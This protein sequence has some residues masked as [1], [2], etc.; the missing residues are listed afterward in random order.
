MYIIIDTFVNQ[1]RLET[2]VGND[3]VS[4]L[5]GARRDG[6]PNDVQRPLRLDI[7]PPPPVSNHRRSSP[8]VY[9]V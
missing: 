4:S 9:A 2:P 6:G 5:D 3:S 8:M 7:I 1:G